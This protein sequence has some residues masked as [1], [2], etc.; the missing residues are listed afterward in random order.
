MTQRNS[1]RGTS[2]TAMTTA[3]TMGGRR[4]VVGCRGGV[5]RA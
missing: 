1:S 3:D 5:T 4:R 2:H